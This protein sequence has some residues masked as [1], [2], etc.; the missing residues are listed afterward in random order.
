M[1]CLLSARYVL[2][3]DILRQSD[4]GDPV[5]LSEQG[6]W[7]EDQD[8]LTGAFVRVWV[9]LTDDSD[10]L[11]PT[12]YS[13]DCMANGIIDGGIR[14]AGTT[15]RF[16]ADYQSIDYVRMFFG[17]QHVLT[18]RD[19]VTNIRNARTGQIIWMDEELDAVN[20]LYS[21]TVF[22]VDGVTPIV[23]P[24]GRHIENFANLKKAEAS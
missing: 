19:R 6:E 20:G 5:N 3:A 15:E 9:P 2:K 16:E 1:Q 13:I 8:P 17:P 14:V 10:P 24:F 22:D 21:A 4:A 18:K 11:A 23:N 12:V 7:K